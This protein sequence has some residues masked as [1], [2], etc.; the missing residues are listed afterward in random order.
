MVRNHTV[1]LDA[2]VLTLLIVG[3]VSED[4][5]P[6]CRRTRHY[7]IGDFHILSEYLER[8]EQMATTPNVVTEV[9]NLIGVLHGKYLQWARQILAGGIN[10][11]SEHYVPSVDASSNP[12]YLRL[13]LTDAALLSV[14][15]RN[16]EIIT[17]DLDLYCCL[18]SD[19]VPVT[20][21]T[22][23]REQQW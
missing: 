19:G 14:R 8:F 17:D 5:I 11:W 4:E 22:H 21:F 2:N 10:L 18:A 6:R 1:L 7:G 23:L 9:S 20:N 12:N 15:E 16:T 13:G 3:Q